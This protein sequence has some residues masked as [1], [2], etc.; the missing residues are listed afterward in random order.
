MV[1]IRFFG[2]NPGEKLRLVG[3]LR[4]EMQAHLR[5][6]SSR[7]PSEP[8]DMAHITASKETSGNQEQERR[9]DSGNM[10][11]ISGKRLSA[12]P[13][14]SRKHSLSSTGTSNASD[15]IHRESHVTVSLFNAH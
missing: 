11:W 4:S 8:R 14:M 9:S 13:S 12:G 3:L 1:Q 5:I 10:V 15:S 7:R 6:G 2:K